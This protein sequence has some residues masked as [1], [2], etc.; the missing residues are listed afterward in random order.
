MGG[1]HNGQWL[2]GLLQ[3]VFRAEDTGGGQLGQL[4]SV[5]VGGL[6]V[7][8]LLQIVGLHGFEIINL[9]EIWRRESARPGNELCA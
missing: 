7:I 5:L 2:D 6:A 8:L 3:L 9:P 1:A 4:G